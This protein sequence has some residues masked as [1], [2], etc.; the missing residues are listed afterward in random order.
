[1]DQETEPIAEVDQRRVKRRPLRGI[2]HQ[3]D[4]ILLA[5][6]AQG[7]NLKLGFARRD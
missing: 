3:T 7:M 6:D 5:T 1:M 4:W 2:K